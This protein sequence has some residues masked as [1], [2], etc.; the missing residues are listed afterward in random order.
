MRFG[1]APLLLLALTRF[2]PLWLRAGNGPIASLLRNGETLA[3]EE[4]ASV[5]PVSRA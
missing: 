1:P 2:S 4:Y 5:F 3:Y